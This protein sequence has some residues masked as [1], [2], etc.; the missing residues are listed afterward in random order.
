M[1]DLES[2]IRKLRTFLIP[3][4]IPALTAS[5]IKDDPDSQSMV[6]FIGYTLFAF[7]GI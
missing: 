1:K 4:A 6:L 7:S 5:P 2:L 3:G